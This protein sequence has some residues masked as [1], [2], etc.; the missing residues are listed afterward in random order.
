MEWVWSSLPVPTGT[1]GW[2][3]LGIGAILAI[4]A[5]TQIFRL[6]NAVAHKVLACVWKT[7]K[8][9]WVYV[10]AMAVVRAAEVVLTNDAHW[11]WAES[12]FNATLNATLEKTIES[13]R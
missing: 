9:L 1:W 8:A 3:A 6:T 11:R 4:F 5:T 13:M 7:I 2:V 10:A 12:W